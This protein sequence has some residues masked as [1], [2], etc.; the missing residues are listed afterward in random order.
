VPTGT[1][2]AVVVEVEPRGPASEAGVAPRDVI[3]EVNR[4]SVASAAEASRELQRLRSGQIAMLL[5]VRGGQEVFVTV[6]KQ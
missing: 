5:I 6:R 1:T 2:G 4:R 3:V